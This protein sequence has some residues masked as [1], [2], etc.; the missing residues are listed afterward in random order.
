MLKV[1]DNCEEAIDYV[2]L[3]KKIKS[4]K[5][6]HLDDRLSKAVAKVKW[7]KPTLVQAA[8]VPLSMEGKDIVCKSKTGSGK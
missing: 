8:T 6:L 5:D 3:A 1:E 2:S 4:F 7:P